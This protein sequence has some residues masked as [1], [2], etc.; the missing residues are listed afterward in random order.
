MAVVWLAYISM[1]GKV[2][3]IVIAV[4]FILF[5]FP[6]EITA[7]VVINEFLPNPSADKQEWVEFYNRDTVPFDLSGYFFDD[8]VSSGSNKK[9]LIGILGPG[10]LCFFDLG[11]DG[12]LNNDGDSPA[13][14]KPDGTVMDTYPYLGS[15]PEDRSYERDPVGIGDFKSDREPTKSDISC[16]SLAPTPTPTPTP[17]PT[18]DPTAAPTSNST[19]TPFPTPTPVKTPTATPKKTPS[20][21]PTVAPSAEVGTPIP[22]PEVQGIRDEMNL[23]GVASESAGITDKKGPPIIPI[24]LISCGGIFIIGAGL[25]LAKKGKSEYNLKENES[26]TQ[27]N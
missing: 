25:A 19:P 3:I 5:L 13:I 12:Y 18:P 6:Q 2:K 8:N 23:L 26:V 14:L 4:I 16:V 9:T 11:K 21:A 10:Q 15:V 27:N 17:S 22:Q 1:S 7:Q 24:I 20:P